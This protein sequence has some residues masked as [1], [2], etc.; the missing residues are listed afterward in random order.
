MVYC[1]V[2]YV[3][4]WSIKYINQWEIILQAVFK[5]F[6][7]AAFVYFVIKFLVLYTT[8]TGVYCFVSVG[9]KTLKV[10]LFVT[11]SWYFHIILGLLVI[12]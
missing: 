6:V 10:C 9:S 4:Y 7:A 11:D 3:P 5:L 1:V 8:A 12:L 2:L